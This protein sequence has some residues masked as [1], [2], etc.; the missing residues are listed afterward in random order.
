MRVQ[1]GA[2]AP[3]NPKEPAEAVQASLKDV[4]AT[5]SLEA[6]SGQAEDYV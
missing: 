5:S 1:G 3:L 4:S 2:A 6:A